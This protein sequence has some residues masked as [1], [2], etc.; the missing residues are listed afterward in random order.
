MISTRLRDAHDLFLAAEYEV[1][2]ELPAEG[3]VVVVV[4]RTQRDSV[5]RALVERPGRAV[6]ILS[7]SDGSIRELAFDQIGGWPDNLVA[8]FATNN[9]VV[10][11]RAIGVPLGIRTDKV[12]RVAY[13]RASTAA[14]PRT[15]LA[16][17]NFALNPDKYGDSEGRPHVRELLSRQLEGADWVTRDTFTG[18]R[19]AADAALAYYAEIARHRFVFSPPGTGADCYRHWEALYLGTVPIVRRSAEMDRFADLPILFTNDYSEITPE[20]LEERWQEMAS[21]SYEVT[22]L[23]KSTYR[24]RFLEAIGQ[25]KAPRFLYIKA[26]DAND[27]RF[28]RVLRR[29]TRSDA[30]GPFSEFPS[31]AVLH[32]AS[33]TSARPWGMSDKLEVRP[34]SD[35]LELETG[36]GGEGVIQQRIL[37]MPGTTLDLRC[38]VDL[39]EP[40]PRCVVSVRSGNARSEL[41]AFPVTETGTTEVRLS[42]PVRQD[43]LVIQISFGDR[44]PGKRMTI[45]SLVAALNFG[46]YRPLEEA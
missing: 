18:K 43:Q 5:L 7:P 9:D 46:P 36:V 23:L 4:R 2:A 14:R 38:L 42:V 3:D 22:T 45:R 19:E 33:L 10:D 30:P 16:Y 27:E 8:L 13:V 26:G 20:Y 24:A 44:E 12:R 32:P 40:L 35:G 6:V 17:A 15:G 28:Q 39:P 34:T 25:L 21:S 1:V 37:V 11:E 29:S 41:N 31:Q